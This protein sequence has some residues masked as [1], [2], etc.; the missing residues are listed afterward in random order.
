MYSGAASGANLKRR[1]SFGNM[2]KERTMQCV[3]N[4]NSTF[5]VCWSGSSQTV[6]PEQQ[7]HR[8]SAEECRSWYGVC[9]DSVCAVWICRW[10]RYHCYLQNLWVSVFDTSHLLHNSLFCLLMLNTAV[11]LLY[12][13]ISHL[14]SSINLQTL[15]DREVMCPFQP[16]SLA[17]SLVVNVSQS[18]G[19]TPVGHYFDLTYFLSHLCNKN[20]YVQTVITK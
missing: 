5:R 14:F 15:F 19:L 16:Q 4:V 18:A 3:C 20:S 11:L 7:H 13:V 10:A 2:L 6:G 8:I 12:V 9:P 17:L 1:K